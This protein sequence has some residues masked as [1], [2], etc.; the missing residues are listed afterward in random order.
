MRP[1]DFTLE[2]TGNDLP[3]TQALGIF[4]CFMEELSGMG[5]LSARR[6]PNFAIRHGIMGDG[7]TI[8]VKCN[9]RTVTTTLATLWTVGYLQSRL[10]S[11]KLSEYGAN[12]IHEGHSWS[13]QLDVYCSQQDSLKSQFRPEASTSPATLL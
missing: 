7:L 4:G 8:T 12:R 1:A 6:V 10:P 11:I 9:G 3:R 2:G 13:Q 5:Q